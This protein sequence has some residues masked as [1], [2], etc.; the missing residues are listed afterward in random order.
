M[1]PNPCYRCKIRK[2]DCH[3]TCDKY[4]EWSKANEKERDHIHKIKN[5]DYLV[6]RHSR[7]SKWW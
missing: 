5:N 6:T 7:W 3:S 1:I 2:S 4:I